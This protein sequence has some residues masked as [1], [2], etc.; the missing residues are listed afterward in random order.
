MISMHLYKI[1][2]NKILNSSTSILFTKLISCVTLK[3]PHSNVKYTYHK[4]AKISIVTKTSEIESIVY[5][6]HFQRIKTIRR[7]EPK[8][9]EHRAMRRSQLK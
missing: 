6:K 2:C 3:Y 7:R 5:T 4:N 8:E 1:F 9:R